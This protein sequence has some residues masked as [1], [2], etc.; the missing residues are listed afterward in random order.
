MI[1]ACTFDTMGDHRRSLF[2]SRLYALSYNKGALTLA[3]SGRG[4]CEPAVRS[5]A[6]LESLLPQAVIVRLHLT[7]D[8][9]VERVE[10]LAKLLVR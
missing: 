8:S 1:A 3:V 5:S 10:F 7:A 6:G 4:G 2:V 9:R